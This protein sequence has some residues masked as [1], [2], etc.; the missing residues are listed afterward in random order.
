MPLI[1]SSKSRGSRM[2]LMYRLRQINTSFAGSLT[3]PDCRHRLQKLTSSSPTTAP[4][5]IQ[6]HR[7]TGKTLF[8]EHWAQWRTT[9]YAD[10][11]ILTIRRVYLAYHDH[12]IRAF[13]ENKPRT[14][15][16]WNRLQVTL[17]RNQPLTSW[18]QPLSTEILKPT[19]RR[20]KRRRI[21][22]CCCCR[23]RQHHHGNLDG[24]HDGLCTRHTHGH[25]S[26]THEEY[27][28]MFAILNQTQDADRRDES[29]TIPVLSEAQLQEQEQLNARIRELEKSLI[30]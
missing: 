25:D 18:W 14:S 11:S 10:S 23:P 9:R 7:P 6:H 13:N 24:V 3:L 20:H 30:A 12:V 27:F 22:Q 29:L 17:S 26:I 1:L 4:R 8:G 28:K 5:P 21:P 15:L 19:T 16:P 2:D